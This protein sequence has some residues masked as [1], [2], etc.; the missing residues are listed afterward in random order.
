MFP[1]FC[2]SQAFYNVL[3]RALR[4]SFCQ[5]LTPASNAVWFRMARTSTR[6]LLNAMPEECN[7]TG[8]NYNTKPMATKSQ[9]PGKE[10]APSMSQTTAV[11]AKNQ[12]AVQ[13]DW[14]TFVCKLAEMINVM[15]GHVWL[16]YGGQRA[17][18]FDLPSIFGY[19]WRACLVPDFHA[20]R[21]PFGC[22]LAL[23]Q[24][25]PRTNEIVEVLH[26]NNAFG[27]AV[28]SLR[29]EG[30]PTFEQASLLRMA[31]LLAAPFGYG[32]AGSNPGMSFEDLIEMLCKLLG[33]RDKRKKT[34]GP[35]DWKLPLMVRW[36]LG[37]WRSFRA[38]S[39][40]HLSVLA[41]HL[42]L[43]GMTL[44]GTLP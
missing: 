1:T 2:L 32:V 24:I 29:M 39:T 10:S 19:A 40:L 26:L 4:P 37:S 23:Y 5:L 22:C 36:V 41:G 13:E 30:N 15:V 11:V 12:K 3:L 9:A 28:A 7:N 14:R 27:A 8:K 33:S 20:Y 43:L 21:I 42:T 25:N 31:R 17:P 35:S 38:L 16:V 44:C 6:A 34:V 18:A